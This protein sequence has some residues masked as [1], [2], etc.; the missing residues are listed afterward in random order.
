[1][2]AIS[3]RPAEAVVI[4]TAGRAQRRRSPSKS[5]W[6]VVT[7]F[8]SPF[9][10]GLAVFVIYPVAATLYYSFTDYQAGSYL[11]VHWVGFANYKSLFT[12]SPVFWV[13]VRN[14]VWMV[15]IM[16][17]LQTLWAIFVAWVLTRIRRGAVIYRTIYFLPAMVP[18]VATALSFIVMLNPVGPLNSLLSHV[19]ITG[20]GWFSDA[21]WSKPSL[22][23]MA[24]WTVGNTMI[25]FL[26]GMLDVPRSLYEAAEIDGA[27][28]W[29]QFRHITI[30]GISPVIFFSLL[31]GM[32]YTFQYFT[33]A[34]VAS[35][36]ANPILSSNES[37]GYPQDSLLFY[38]TE[39]YRQGFQ[40]FK[41]GYA[42]AM[43]WLLFMVIFL[44]TLA[45]IRG[46]R[47]WVHYAGATR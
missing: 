44:C 8:M 28:S 14:T 39:I 32:I 29:Q 20:P 25:L 36:S 9:L 4:A 45:F 40:Y 22:V 23:L 13:A 6:W 10:I 16:V 7:A 17:P 24:M 37:I 11:P 27:N 38:T 2:T 15:A 26:A 35:G 41:T 33:E 42:S 34:F 18:I 19:G 1:M 21:A 3:T 43:A 31:T 5:R 12:E 30:P 47:R 46:S